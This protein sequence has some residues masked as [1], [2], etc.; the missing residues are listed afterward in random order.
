MSVL[1]SDVI[2]YAR[3]KAQTDSNGITD[4][5]GLA[6]AND[7]LLD[8]TRLLL[9]RDIDASQIQ[10]AYAS[11]TSTG[12][13][14]WPSDMYALKTV[15]VNFTDSNQANYIQAG[16]V[17]IANLQGDTSF[18]YLRVYQPTTSP[19]F[20]N[21]GDTG[22]IFPN[23]AATVKIFYF[24][25]PTEYSATSTALSYPQTLDYRALGD[26][27]VSS[28]YYS[29]GDIQ[30][31]ERFANFYTA[32]INDLIRILAP[33]SQQPITPQKLRITGWEF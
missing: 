8:M 33:Q 19:L 23:A 25:T 30:M 5:T 10:E 20:N 22:E 15:E 32:R 28:Y 7:A 27:V 9:N 4:T 1:V 24:L 13:F 11:V 12:T 16:K 6:W 31:G 2:T 17:D 21:H 3:Q 26:K 18:D 14:A 29:Q